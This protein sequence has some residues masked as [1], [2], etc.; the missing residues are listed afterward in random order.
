MNKLFFMA[1]GV[2]IALSGT[3][4]HAA[5]LKAGSV[6]CLSQKYLERYLSFVRANEQSFANTMLDRAQC[7]TQQSN[8][9]VAVV[10]GSGD[11]LKVDTPSGFSV[12]VERDAVVVEQTAPAVEK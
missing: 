6:A 3:S 1:I 4:A 11:K 9:Q 10:A 12:W 5:E 7:Y 8:Q 2:A